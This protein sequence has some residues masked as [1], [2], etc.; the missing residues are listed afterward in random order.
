MYQL[1]V[2]E[3]ACRQEQYVVQMTSLVLKPRYCTVMTIHQLFQ[4]H[5][6]HIQFLPLGLHNHHWE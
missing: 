5:T 3:M 1:F 6:D 2:A 4:L